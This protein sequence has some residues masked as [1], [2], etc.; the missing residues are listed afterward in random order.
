MNINEEL[1]KLKAEIATHQSEIN[2]HSFALKTKQ[3]KVKRLEKQLEK[4]NE[5]INEPLPPAV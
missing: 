3:A 5:I 1:N 2:A 4:L